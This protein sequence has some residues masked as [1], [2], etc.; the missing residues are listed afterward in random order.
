MRKLNKRKNQ[1]DNSVEMYTCNCSC[2]GCSC[3]ACGILFFLSNSNQTIQQGDH[4][5]PQTDTHIQPMRS[6]FRFA[7][8]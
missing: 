3:P 8:G 7:S 4:S 2:S 6:T 5:G 1:S